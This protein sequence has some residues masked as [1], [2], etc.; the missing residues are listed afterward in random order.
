MPKNTRILVVDD[1]PEV[2][3]TYLGVLQPLR[4]TVSPLQRFAHPRQE[5]GVN[6]TVFEVTA[7]LQGEDAV[8]AV[9]SALSKQQPFAGAFVDVR[10][11]PGIDGVETARRIRE[12]D[13]HIYIMI[14]SA[15]SDRTVEEM[16]EAVKHDLTYARKPLA[17]DEIVQL[18]RNACNSWEGDEVLRQR[19]QFL[20]QMVDEMAIARWNAE[21]ALAS[22]PDGVLT[23][24]EGG[25]LTAANPVALEMLQ[26]G[27]EALLYQPVAELL[28]GL[29]WPNLVTKLREHGPIRDLPARLH[30][31]TPPGDLPV[32][33]SCSLVPPQ[34]NQPGQLI[35]MVRPVGGKPT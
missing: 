32:R 34:K 27:I 12:L 28:P 6:A 20:E 2:I 24:T 9:Q 5:G 11:P 23:C 19:F 17:N 29:E 15:Y 25:L 10:M 13:N 3:K 18:A 35:L 8:A 31:Q 22:L 21:N 4:D 7:V 30:R 1:D 16:Q 33:L 26:V 14:V